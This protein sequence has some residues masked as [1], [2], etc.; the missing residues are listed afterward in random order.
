LGK[1]MV[2]G[3]DPGNEGAIAVLD[4]GGN[5]MTV[6][7][8]PV[9]K[10]EMSTK[11]P[12]GNPKSKTE[13][14]I[15]ELVSLLERFMMDPQVGEDRYQAF[16]IGVPLQVKDKIQTHKRN[17]MIGL[18][19]VNAGVFG[20]GREGSKM[21][22]TS[23]F[24]FGKGFGTILGAITALRI[25]F[26]EIHPAT[27][28]AAVLAGMA[29]DKSGSVVKACQLF[30]DKAELFS[31]RKGKLV[32]NKDGRAEAAL[33]AYYIYMKHAVA[34]R[35]APVNTVGVRDL[36]KKELGDG[37]L[38]IG[39]NNPFSEYRTPAG[40]QVTLTLGGPGGPTY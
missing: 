13:I 7:D 39:E 18:E 25:P 5:L 24:N 34:E 29:K 19:K 32:V 21:G 9:I 8:M 4:N 38:S 6:M 27:W 16:E 28:K 3:I 20:K 33:I 40:T 1:A 30:P 22:A 37:Q 12:K 17:L 14:H 35:V 15:P 2:I 31:Y 11:T 10:L 26:E 23:A 36:L